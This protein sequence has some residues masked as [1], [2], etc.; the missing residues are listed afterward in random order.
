ML[1]TRP[2]LRA[3]IRGEHYIALYQ[4]AERGDTEAL[5]ALLACGLDVNRG[6]DEIG[7]T[8]LHS[9]AHGGRPDVVRVLLEHGASVAVRDREFHAQPLVWAAEASRAPHKDGRDY[10]AVGQLLLDAGSPVD[11][12]TGDEP[13]EQILDI[14]AEWRRLQSERR[15]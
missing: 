2:A 12:E 14:L 9:A 1:A 5:E 8:A 10:V 13:A 7:K 11:W 6:D 4:A 15:S 3:E